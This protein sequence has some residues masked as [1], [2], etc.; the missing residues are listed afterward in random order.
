MK[1]NEDEIPN[2]FQLRENFIEKSFWF[3]NWID[4]IYIIDGIKF[5]DFH[6]INNDTPDDN[7]N[8]FEN[9]RRVILSLKFSLTSFFSVGCIFD[10]YGRLLKF[11][12]GNNYSCDVITLGED[13]QLIKEKENIKDLLGNIVYPFPSL[14]L[15]S[16]IYYFTTDVKIK[17]SSV[18]VIIPLLSVCSYLYFKSEIITE[19][20]MSNELSYFVSFKETEKD[21]IKIGYVEYDNSKIL[22]NEIRSIAPFF[23]LKDSLGVKSLDL[24]G[25]YMLLDL[26][27]NRMEGID[28]SIYLNT[29]IPFPN[30]VKLELAG[31]MITIKNEK[32]FFSYA[33]KNIIIKDDLFTVAKVILIPRYNEIRYWEDKIKNFR[34]RHKIKSR[35]LY[36]GDIIKDYNGVYFP[37]DFFL[38]KHSYSFRLDIENQM[39]DDELIEIHHDFYKNNSRGIA[40]KSNYMNLMYESLIN[41]IRFQKVDIIVFDSLIFKRRQTIIFVNEL[42]FNVWVI[43]IKYRD[44]YFYLIDF[45]RGQIGIVS[46]VR[47]YSRI[48]PLTMKILLHKIIYNYF[49]YPDFYFWFKI[50]QDKSTFIKEYGIDI[51]DSLEYNSQD[52]YINN[53]KTYENISDIEQKFDAF[54]R[55]AV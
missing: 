34:H 52:F 37:L 6:F 28:K 36:E 35:K 51:L 15:T 47:E 8:K 31:K 5:A 25:S 27:Q 4:G 22:K 38:K 46:S 26:I 2:I 24:I 42:E 43:E 54:I 33:V 41:D 29:I 9:N 53:N 49:R 11:P 32:Y 55:N 40:L 10:E 21:K 12:E 30:T 3:L 16:E 1:I 44:F 19:L 23:F 48:T 17:E 13:Y 20:I 14:S 50:K 39:S 45:L 7:F 18:K